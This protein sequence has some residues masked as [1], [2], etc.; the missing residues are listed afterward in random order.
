MNK[1]FFP[2]LT[3]ALTFGLLS[4]FSVL[5]NHIFFDKKISMSMKDIEKLNSN[6][7]YYLSN[8]ISIKDSIYNKI[9]K[10]NLGFILEPK[11][12]FFLKKILLPV[13]KE[14]NVFESN[15]LKSKSI[16]F[17][18]Y[19]T[20]QFIEGPEISKEFIELSE[21][22]FVNLY[23]G[24][25]N[26]IFK[27]SEGVGN[28]LIYLDS[29]KIDPTNL[30]TYNS[31]L[32]NKIFPSSYESLILSYNPFLK[33]F[34]LFC[35][36]SKFSGDYRGIEINLETSSA[37][38]NSKNK[39]TYK[40]LN[41]T[42][43]SNSLII[44]NKKI[45]IS[46]GTKIEFQN[47]A[48]L[49]AKD[50]DFISNSKNEKI[51]WISRDNNS[52]IFI[53]CKSVEISNN[54]FLGFSNKNIDGFSLPSAI[55]FYNSKVEIINSIFKENKNGDDYINLFKS[56]FFISDV[57]FIDT[58]SDALDVDFSDGT[59]QSS[60]FQNIGND[61]IDASGSSLII[62]NNLISKS[63]DK[64]ISLG[65]NSFAHINNNIL[66]DSELGI[67]CK[68]GSYSIIKNNFFKNR[69]DICAFNK[70][71]FYKKPIIESC[72]FNQNWNLLVEE[73][74]LNIDLSNFLN[75]NYS[76]NVDNL[77]YGNLYGKS[78]N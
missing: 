25:K 76:K 36:I 63:A 38:I 68:D 55:T 66:T 35:D 5:S 21:R 48:S 31:L 13:N 17:N 11:E 39:Q 49:V 71:S 3:L 46:S 44:S 75:I 27:K 53:N 20:Q 32:E 37:R 14:I 8:G 72:D 43:I 50:C 77:L 57:S 6:S 54:S 45:I 10:K 60:T 22:R 70:K 1:S 59:I 52:L 9:Y 34:E 47:D 18:D 62:E 24:L 51:N 26:K 73:G 64:A 42:I 15:F 41:D 33:S 7:I 56:K 69:I 29:I 58:F 74:T 65:E 61:A 28:K 19:Q 16:K 12:A 67:V 30:K 4:I 40:I 2:F 23:S 78:S